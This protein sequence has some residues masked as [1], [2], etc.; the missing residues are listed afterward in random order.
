MLTTAGLIFMLFSW[1][2]ILGVAGWCM[3]RILFS[4]KP[5]NW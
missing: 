1:A 5:S 4:K 2:T 3:Y